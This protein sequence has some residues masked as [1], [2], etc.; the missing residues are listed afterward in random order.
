MHA[1]ELPPDALYGLLRI[2]AH[3]LF[4]ASRVF[5]RLLRARPNPARD[6]K[7]NRLQVEPDAWVGL[8]RHRCTGALNV[9]VY[10]ISDGRLVNAL[11]HG[12][13]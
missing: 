9:V 1:E 11:V 13:A 12:V 8:V 10:L 7:R 3:R 6:R 5:W 4:E 2:E